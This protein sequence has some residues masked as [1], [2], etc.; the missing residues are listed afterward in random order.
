MKKIKKVLVSS[1]LS[2]TLLLP[3]TAPAAFAAS[4][5]DFWFEFKHQVTSKTYSRGAS[6]I[7]INTHADTGDK[8]GTFNIEL[9]RKQKKG[10]A[11]YL[12]SKKFSQNGSTTNSYG[13]KT[14]G[15]FY[16]IMKKKNNGASTGGYGDIY[17]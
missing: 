2:F 7:K 5:H 14:K 11:K 13:N 8:G 4:K 9:Y 16:F 17:N 10:K 3:V 15:K 6:S 1:A 12:G